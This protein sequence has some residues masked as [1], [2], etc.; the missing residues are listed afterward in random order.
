MPIFAQFTTTLKFGNKHG[1]Q[2]RPKD[3]VILKDNFTSSKIY[4]MCFSII[5]HFC[6]CLICFFNINEVHV[7]NY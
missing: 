6:F 1:V 5:M 4:M 2:L 7:Y 3:T